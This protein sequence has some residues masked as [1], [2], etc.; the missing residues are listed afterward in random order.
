MNSIEMAQ[1]FSALSS[2]TRIRLLQI[3][4]KKALNCCNPEEC[5]LSEHCCNVSE[6]AKELGIAISTTS[7]H[8]K[9]L[10]QIGLIQSRRQGQQIFCSLKTTLLEDLS[11]FF[12][13]FAQ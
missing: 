10:R 9:E 5:D 1:I 2:D 4:R 3:L 12:K 13:S 8:L 7:F 11:Q 6:L